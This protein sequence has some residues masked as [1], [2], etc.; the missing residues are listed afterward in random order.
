MWS[1]VNIWSIG[2]TDTDWIL[3]WHLTFSELTLTLPLTL[4]LSR[5]GKK[6]YVRIFT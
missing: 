3:H 5:M 1:N 4:K 6:G 2:V